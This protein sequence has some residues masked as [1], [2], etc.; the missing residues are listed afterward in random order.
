[1]KIEIDLGLGEIAPL[2]LERGV[3]ERLNLFA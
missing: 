3:T 1:M 2:R